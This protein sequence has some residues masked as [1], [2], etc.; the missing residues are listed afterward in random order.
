[1]TRETLMQ[2]AIALARRGQ[3]T[4]TPNPSVGCVVVKDGHMIGEG[5]TS[6]AG[7]NHA[8]INALEKVNNN[9][10]SAVGASVYVTLEPCSHY[11]RTPPCADALIAAGIAEIIIGSRDPNPQVSGRG[12]KKLRASGIVVIEDLL[13]KQCDE[14]YTGFF[15]RITTG[16]PWVTVKLGMTLDAKVATASGESQ[17]ITSEPSR[18]DV[19]QLRAQSC[20]IMTS[21]ATVIA[22]NPSLNV[23]LP[24]ITRQPK[25]VVVDSQL[26]VPRTAKIFN[27]DGSVLVYALNSAVMTSKKQAWQV[28]PPQHCKTM[29][30]NMPNEENDGVTTLHNDAYLIGVTEKNNHADL[31]VVLKDL[32]SN[33]HCNHVLVEAGGNFVGALLEEDLVDELV[34]YTAPILLGDQGKPAFAFPSVSTLDA[35]PRFTVVNCCQ[36]GSDIKWVMR[37][38]QR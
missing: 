7:G 30:T 9:G 26:T 3:N 11:G 27:L 29:G 6:P 17:W 32:G 5:F 21:S 10:F 16:M 8:E 12:V 13:R 37:K 24:N 31:T 4:T 23:R 25:R 28:S 20:A 18:A 14:L 36:T 33:Q 19:Q 22:D 38:H 2:H 34:V 15:K 1:M 35:A